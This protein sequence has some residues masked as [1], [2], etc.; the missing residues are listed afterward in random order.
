MDDRGFCPQDVSSFYILLSV[1]TGSAFL[2]VCTD[3]TGY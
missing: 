1:E 2:R 3:I